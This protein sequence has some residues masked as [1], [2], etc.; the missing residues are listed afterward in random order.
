[1]PVAGASGPDGHYGLRGMKERAEQIRA[2][3]KVES[4]P[5][6][7]AQILVQTEIE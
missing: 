2:Q 3:F 4:S 1:M 5:G 7:G 6:K